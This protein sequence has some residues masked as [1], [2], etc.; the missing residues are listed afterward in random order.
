MAAEI[1]EFAI[2]PEDKAELD[3]LVSI[4]AGGDRSKFLREAVRVMAARERAERL[5]QVQAAIH[6]QT[7]GPKTSGQVTTDVRHVVKGK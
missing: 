4:I 7:G 1:I 2:Q 3:R 6:A 5:Q